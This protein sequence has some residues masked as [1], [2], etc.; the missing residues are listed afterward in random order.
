MDRIQ[1]LCFHHGQFVIAILTHSPIHILDNSYRSC[2]CFAVAMAIT[3]GIR[4]QYALSSIFM[5]TFATQTYGYLTEYFSRPSYMPTPEPEMERVRVSTQLVLPSIDPN[6]WE[7][8]TNTTGFVVDP[9]N[10]VRNSAR[11]TKT[12]NYLSRLLPH[13]FGWF[14]M[15]SVWFILVAQL[16]NAK[17]DLAEVSDRKMPGWVGIVIY[18]SFFIFTSFAFV[19]IYFQKTKPGYYFGTEIAYCILSLTAKMYLGWFLLINVIF[20]DGS[21]ADETLSGG[22]DARM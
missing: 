9:K 16:E 2:C 17:R 7:G 4:E 11:A 1:H 15:S 22:G 10:W 3:L 13:A 14:T 18:G 21:T 6:Q 19:Q 20:I 8:D 12:R 5:L